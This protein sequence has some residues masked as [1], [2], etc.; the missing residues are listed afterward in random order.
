MQFLRNWSETRQTHITKFNQDINITKIYIVL[1]I[2]TW[3]VQ[4]VHVSPGYLS[5]YGVI[6][7]TIIII[8]FEG[9][10][11]CEYFTCYGKMTWNAG[12]V[13]Y[14][15]RGITLYKGYQFIA[16]TVHFIRRVKKIFW[17]KMWTLSVGKLN[18]RIVNIKNNQEW[19][20]ILQYLQLILPLSLQLWQETIPS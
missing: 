3:P 17:M 18:S 12:A 20:Q 13:C 7:T 14:T 2:N 16:M 8:N 10:S 15:A 1:Q 19:F 5:C 6:T 11:M 9:W 4:T